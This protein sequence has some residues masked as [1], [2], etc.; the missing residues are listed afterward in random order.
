[1]TA[2]NNNV[3]HNRRK[4]DSAIAEHKAITQKH[5]ESIA[6]L[7]TDVASLQTG[8]E[9][10]DKGI[11]RIAYKIDSL[12]EPKPTNWTGVGSLIVAV[13][14]VFGGVFSFLFNAQ[15]KSSVEALDYLSSESSL[16]HRIQ[17]EQ[18]EY[19]SE[20]YNR[21]H[22][23]VIQEKERQADLNLHFTKQHKE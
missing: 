19:I 20:Q 18:I 3:Q 4:S 21:L 1:M 15:N 11:G 10:L 5:G 8:L 14:I 23:R 17:A 12:T 16:R 2:N 22:D 9:N 6:M 13:I 7:R